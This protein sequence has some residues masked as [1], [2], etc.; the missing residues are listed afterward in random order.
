MR[1]RQVPPPAPT[2]AGTPGPE[3]AERPSYVGDCAQRPAGST[4][5]KFADGYVW[6]VDDGVVGWGEDE[7]WD[8]KTV[9]V[10]Q[11]GQ[12]T[13][14]HVLDTLLVKRIPK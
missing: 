2:P 4:C 13:Y 10:V 11:G 6:L 3:F 5:V 9:Q 12:A 7:S 1:R 8:G 14:Y